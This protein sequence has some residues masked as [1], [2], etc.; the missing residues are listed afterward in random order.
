MQIEYCQL[1]EERK[2]MSIQF[3]ELLNKIEQLKNRFLFHKQQI[4]TKIFLNF[5]FVD[6]TFMLFHYVH[7]TMVHTMLKNILLLK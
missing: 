3:K 2:K 4:S 7:L 5:F 1:E 6:M